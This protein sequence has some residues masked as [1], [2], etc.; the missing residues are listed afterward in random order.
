MARYYG[1]GDEKEKKDDGTEQS[2]S[3]RHENI[4]AVKVI[5]PQTCIANRCGISGVSRYQAMGMY[6]LY[7]HMLN[8]PYICPV[9]ELTSG[10]LRQA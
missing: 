3:D 9:C 6:L 10:N 1:R 8:S 4:G 5:P 2:L 7:L